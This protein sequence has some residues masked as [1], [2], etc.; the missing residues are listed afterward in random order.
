MPEKGFR[1]PYRLLQAGIGGRGLRRARE[2]WVK[3]LIRQWVFLFAILISGSI[4]S[5]A[6]SY[7]LTVA[8]LV[9]S[10]NAAG[11]N[12][13]TANPGAYQRYAERYFENF[14]IPYQLFDVATTAPPA[15][16]GNHQLII[17]A[18]PGLSLS[19]AWQAALMAAVNAG[20]G[21]VNLDSDPAIGSASH[22]QAIFGATGSGLGTSATS[23]T[24]PFAMTAGGATPHYIAA[25]QMKTLEPAG[26]FIYNFHADQNGNVNPVTATVLEGASGTVIA[27]IGTDPL[28]LAT[29][30]GAGR[31]VNFGTLDYLQADRFGFLEGVDDLFWRSLAWA[32]RKPFVMRAYPRFWSLRLDYNVDSGWISRLRAMYD[33]TL[34]GTVAADGTGGPWKVTGSVN[35]EFLPAGDPGRDQA[36]ADIN[37][38][39][40]QISAHG[41]NKS[42][43]GDLFWG[44]SSIPGRALTDLEWQNNV[45]TLQQFQQGNGGSD[46]IPFFSQW[47]VSQFYNLSNNIGSDLASTFGARYIGTTIKPGFPYA[48]SPSD[49]PYQQERLHARPYW[50]YQLPPKPAGVLPSDESYSFFFA[51]DLTIAS[52]AGLPDQ[53]F[54]LV[55]SRAIDLSFAATPAL[56]WCNSQGDGAAFSTARF[57]WYSW[58][59]FSSLVP[60]E[61]YTQDDAFQQCALSPQPSN[62]TFHNGAEQIIHDLATWLNNNGARPIFMQDMAQYIY[63]RTKST[64][65]RATFD[66]GNI[67]YTFTGDSADPDGNLVP[68]QALVFES[69]TQEHWETVPGFRNGLTFTDGPQPVAVGTKLSFASNLS[70][71]TL[72]SAG[73]TAQLHFLVIFSNGTTQDLTNA[74]GTSYASSAPDVATVSTTGLV[75]AVGSGVSTITATDGNLAAMVTADVSIPPPPDFSVPATLGSATIAAG[76]STIFQMSVGSIS[77][78]QQTVSF[79]CSGAPV[80]AT[81]SVNPNPA[82]PG[83]ADGVQVILNTTARAAS[84]PVNRNLPAPPTEMIVLIAG[85]ETLI[86]ALVLTGR[87]RLISSAPALMLLMVSVGCGGG[88]GSSP[89]PPNPATGSTGTPAGTY[90]LT[91]TGTSGTHSHSTT[92]NLIVK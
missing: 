59:L 16:L 5:Y 53:K 78:F 8:V 80:G 38:G 88:G 33:P 51:D 34:T 67:T 21:F 66:A 20:T 37:A 13:D 81:C 3:I 77:G 84:F 87:R 11:F 73:S 12:T 57:E 23:I 2:A 31:A 56:N 27:R 18:H 48:L 74:A 89:A 62:T 7:D 25:L 92:A 82:T 6:Q 64:L 40:L 50:L 14:Q 30:F 68:T 72:T 86:L 83:S 1:L 52:R 41:F 85:L 75:T 65:T 9:N 44:G 46:S 32:A 90:V 17:A 26:D 55:G 69:D 29:S 39:K 70:K 54:F 4:S 79:V 36:I 63:A 45:A 60:A 58:R 71:L 91:I 49:A 42:N 35:T 28:I 61:V 76:Q 10:S 43:F 19:P 22:I 47:W 24:I 15:D